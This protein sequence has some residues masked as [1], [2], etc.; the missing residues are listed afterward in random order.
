MRLTMRRSLLQLSVY[1]L[2]K[3]SYLDLLDLEGTRHNDFSR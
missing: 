3:K 1:H 2:K